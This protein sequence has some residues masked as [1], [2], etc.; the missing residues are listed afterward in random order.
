MISDSNLPSSSLVRSALDRTK[1]AFRPSTLS[2]HNTHLRTYLSFTIF[3][4][5]PHSPSVHSILALM[6]FLY[7]NSLSYKVIHTIFHPLN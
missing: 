4:S 2:A 1:T 5:L 3:M 6:E 7:A